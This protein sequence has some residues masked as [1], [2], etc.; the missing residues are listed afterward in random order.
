VT[1]LCELLSRYNE[2]GQLW[3][4]R[5]S[6]VPFNTDAANGDRGAIVNY[7]SNN[8]VAGGS[9]TDNN[10][11]LIRQETYIPGSNYFQDNLVIVSTFSP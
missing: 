1:A 8:F 4:I 5:A 11:N 2:R 10:G 6:T 3:D 9:G 7:Y